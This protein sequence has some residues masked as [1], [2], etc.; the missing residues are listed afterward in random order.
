MN[1]PM[2]RV[3]DDGGVDHWKIPVEQ[4]YRQLLIGAEV[5]DVSI[6]ARIDLP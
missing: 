6:C 5:M 1:L 4:R 3:E 2:L